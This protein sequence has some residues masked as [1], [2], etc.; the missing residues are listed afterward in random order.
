[1]FDWLKS[2]INNVKDLN[3]SVDE[4]KNE[5]IIQS[6]PSVAYVN[7]AKT[8]IEEKDYDK[9][10]VILRKALDISQDDSIANK[11]LGKIYELRSDFIGAIEYYKKSSAVNPNDKEIWLRLGMCQLNSKKVE[12]SILSF[13]QANKV[14]AYNTDVYTGWGMALMRQ[15]KYALAHDKFL[16]ATQI[17]K[18]NYTA[19]LL[20]A[21]MEIRLGDYENAEEK[22]KFLAKI[23]PNESS[24]YEYAHLKLL[25]EDYDEAEKY[26]KK[27]LEYNSQ[28]LPAYLLLGEVYSLQ[29][30]KEKFE[31]IFEKA[32]EN[33][34][35]SSNL[36]REWGKAYIRIFEYKKAKEQFFVSLKMDDEDIDSKMGLA[37]TQAY[38]NDFE[39]LKELRGVKSDNSY[40]QEALGLEALSNKKAE[41]AIDYFKKSLKMEKRQTYNYYNLARSYI[42]LDDKYK[43]KDNYEKFLSENPENIRVLLEYAK[44]LI[45]ISDNAEAQRK[46]KRAE[47]IEK[48]NVEVLN[49]LFLSTYPLVKNG[50]CEYNIREA[51]SIAEKAKVL[52]KFDYENEE[53]ELQKILV[54]IQGKK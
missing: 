46:L 7:K 54:D 21:I 44:W 47:K 18:Y 11:Y 45:S 15:K 49:L 3:G 48:N 5:S 16:M 34:L 42:L 12:D 9:A 40:I 51:I 52:G 14:T 37:L 13:E 1:M 6:I 25:K 41:D 22:L 28:M 17:S 43:V 30:N 8:L 27:S 4:Y 39:L 19:I 29:K 31:H 23:A 35:E 24:T 10:E 38:E 53:I 36:R 2:V 50:G 26:A 33:D 20:S 32:L